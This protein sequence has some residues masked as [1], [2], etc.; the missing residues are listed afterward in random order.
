VPVGVA[1][2]LFIGGESLARGY[3]NRPELNAEKFISLFLEKR[4]APPVRVYRTGDRVRWTRR[5]ELEFLDRIDSQ[6]KVRGCR[7]ELGEIETTLQTHPLVREALVLARPDERGELQLVAY[8]LTG[9][10]RAPAEHGDLLV[11]LRGKLPAY[12]IPATIVALPAWPLTPNG[13]IDR[14]SL[15]APVIGRDAAVA[16]LNGSALEPSATEKLVSRTWEAVM[17]RGPILHEENFFDVGGHSLLAAQVITRL[18]AALPVRIPVR[19]LFDF[20]IL[21]DFAREVEGRVAGA[22]SPR[23]AALRVTR[24]SARPDLELANP[25]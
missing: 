18:N 13:K 21:G 14:L 25:S 2:E 20:P 23:S 19:V 12:M 8:V 6:V 1:G 4:G 3:L 24:R 9:S 22:V 17:G 16:A 5:G 7:I 10:D 15:P 11:F